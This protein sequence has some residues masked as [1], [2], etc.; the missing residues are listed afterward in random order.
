MFV[1][2]F[3]QGGEG[4]ILGVASCQYLAAQVAALSRVRLVGAAELVASE[5]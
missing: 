4:L 5:A 1:R 3:A 2:C